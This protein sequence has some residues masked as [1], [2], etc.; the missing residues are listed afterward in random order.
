MAIALPLKTV[1]PIGTPARVPD[2][3]YAKP[4]TQV[5]KVTANRGS[6]YFE[7][8]TKLTHGDQ[9]LLPK[10]G[11]DFIKTLGTVHATR[12]KS[13]AASVLHAIP[14]ANTCLGYRYFA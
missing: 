5:V 8:L 11:L 14:A 2:N 3:R 13:S 4:V 6:R 9:T 12:L 1:H 7:Y 10:K